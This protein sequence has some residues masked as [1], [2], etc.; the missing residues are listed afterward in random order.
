MAARVFEDDLC[1]ICADRVD[2]SGEQ[3]WHA[4]GAVH[5][6]PHIDAVLLV[7]HEYGEDEDG[8]EVI[9]IISARR[10]EKHEIRRYQEQEIH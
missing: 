4:L 10:A 8:E 9:R 6:E 5:A 3:R 7:V 1:L 2:K